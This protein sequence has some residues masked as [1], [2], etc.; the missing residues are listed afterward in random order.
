MA[1][2][3]R[4]HGERS[5]EGVARSLGRASPERQGTDRSAAATSPAPERHVGNRALHS[6]AAAGDAP[7]IQAM[8]RR[9]GCPALAAV[10]QR[11]AIHRHTIDRYEFEADRTADLVMGQRPPASAPAIQPLG[12]PTAVPVQ[13]ATEEEEREEAEGD[14]IDME[15]GIQAKADAGGAA[16][17]SAVS[18]PS[19]GGQLLPAQQRAF[20]E[21]RFGRDLGSVRVHTD[22]EA[23]RS[24][25]SLGALAFTQGNNVVFRAGEYSP[26]SADG[27]WL[28]AHELTHVAQQGH[29]PPLG[30]EALAASPA[31][32][33]APQRF[34]D[35]RIPTQEAIDAPYAASLSNDELDAAI[36]EVQRVLD[37]ESQSSPYTDAVY[38][39]LGILKAERFARDN[40]SEMPREQQ[41]PPAEEEDVPFDEKEFDVESEDWAA[42]QPV[43]GIIRGDPARLRDGP[44]EHAKFVDVP[45]NT[46]LVVLSA[47]G[48]WSNVTLD[49]GRKGWVASKLVETKLPDPDASLYIVEAGDTAQEIARNWYGKHSTEWGQDERYFV[50]VLYY[51]NANFPAQGRD[52]GITRPAGKEDEWDATTVKTGHRIW[53]PGLAYA[54]GLKAIVPS[55]SLTYEAWQTIKD[56]F[57]GTAG[58]ISGLLVGA[59]ESVVD[60]FVGLWDLVKMAWQV[61][62][63]LITGE[64]ISDIRKLWDDLSKLT[65]DDIVNA[66]I[67]WFKAKWFAEGTWD[68]WYNRGR[69]IG[70]VIVEILMLF[71]SGGIATAVK[72][73]GKTGKFAKLVETLPTLRKMVKAAENVTGAAAD[74]LRIG[75]KALSKAHHWAQTVLR[76]P[77][78]IIKDTSAAALERLRGLSAW[79][80]EK[81][82]HLNPF[83]MKCVLG[84][85][86]PCRVNIHEIEEYLK[87]LAAKGVKVGAKL[88][89]D[90][91]KILASLPADRMDLSLIRKKLKTRPALKMLIDSADLTAEDMAKIADF[92]SLGGRESAAQSYRTFVRYLTAVVPAKTEG[93]IDKFNKIAAAII[94][95]DENATKAVNT[96]IV[97]QGSAL[98]GSMFE[99]FAKLYLQ[100]QMGGKEFGR[101][102]FKSSAKLKLEKTQR[103]A[104]NFVAATGE[105]WEIKHTTGKV[106]ADQVRDYQT[107]LRQAKVTPEGD[108]VR[109]VNYLF[110]SE[111]AAEA[112]RHLGAAGFGVYY[113]VGKTMV[114]LL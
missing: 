114:P 94:K 79:A 103:T 66:G 45:M 19:S 68:R 83:A 5:A 95:T 38:A 88:G 23:D 55:G 113:I 60:V 42:P 71:F 70:Y 99:G 46:K 56:I 47:H 107:I 84:C 85:T 21:P 33:G 52:S 96:A 14:T 62:K 91:E 59:L 82:R 32:D 17:G 29:A 41:A 28:L 64:I 49:D 54:L 61:I 10:A 73:V 86:S 9:P 24:A 87:N 108:K 77:F 11:R 63:S 67:A 12:R 81:F 3:S 39:N 51:T 112:N 6:L 7:L 74:A 105:I 25:R 34:A 53:I 31:I 93:D 4:A 15:F 102:T 40:S 8:C 27:G 44:S 37:L 58:F 109:A 92:V 104:D 50:N 65:L 100:E 78:E 30:P 35:P 101:V 97:R 75:A 48:G 26:A 80:K 13:K 20:L 2:T 36:A 69:M 98:K 90:A 106:P 111:K 18:L 72:W 43:P 16:A 110:P 76:I 89:Q 57:V 1:T 22:S